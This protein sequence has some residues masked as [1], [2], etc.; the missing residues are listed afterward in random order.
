[1][2]AGRDAELDFLR[3]RAEEAE[4]GNGQVVLVRSSVG[5]GKTELLSEFARQV[6]GPNSPFLTATCTAGE[7]GLPMGVLSQLF[8][9]ASLSPALRGSL[10]QLLDRGASAVSPT[11]DTADAVESDSTQVFN[12]FL[13][14]LLELGGRRLVLLCVDDVEYAD[15]PSLRCLLYLARRLR[16]ARV[17]IVLSESRRLPGRVSALHTEVGQLPDLQRIELP[18]LSPASVA[19]LRAEC[20]PAE[21][22]ALD[23]HAATGGNPAFV[24]A[25][26]GDLGGSGAPGQ[27]YRQAVIDCLRRCEDT[28]AEVARALA[29]LGPESDRT[30]LGGLLDLRPE[31]V[32]EALALLDDVGLTVGTTFRHDMASVA[33]RDDL[34]QGRRALLHE[35]AARLLHESGK[36]AVTVARHLVDA[37]CPTGRRA[38]E[39]L[40]EASAQALS[41]DRV[42]FAVDC[43]TLALAG[44]AD[45]PRRVSVL[46]KLARAE[47]Q[48]N[49]SAMLRHVDP[50]MAGMRAGL[51]DPRDAITLVRQLLWHGRLGQ[52]REVLD[53]LRTLGAGAGSETVTELGYVERW[54]T[55]CYPSLN[56]GQCIPRSPIDQDSSRSFRA[57][58]W[59][60]S[61]AV[62]A[63]TFRLGEQQDALAEAERFLATTQL[64]NT[65][66]WS[67]EP[68]MLALLALVQGDR[69]EVAESCCERLL[70]ESTSREAPT[71]RA[72]F[73]AV[74]A[75]AALR[76]GDLGS[77]AARAR[78]AMTLVSPEAW[79]VGIGLPLGSLILAATLR[80]AYAEARG[81]V[82]QPV[83][84][85]L[86]QSRYGPHYLHARGHFYSETDCHHAALAD[87]L[88]CGELQRSWG[89]D[90]PGFVPWRTS[91]AQ[92]WLRLGNR[93]R[94][95]RLVFD[96]LARTG[97]GRTRSRALALRVLATAGQVNRRP[98]LLAEAVDIFEDRGDRLELAITLTELSRAH[99]ALGAHQR[100]RLTVRRAWHLA[101]AC[102]AEPLIRTLLSELG[103]TERIVASPSDSHGI[104]SLTGSERRVASLAVAG[105]SNREIAKKLF[106]TPSTVEQH[107]TRVYRKLRVKHR[108]DLPTYLHADLANS[109]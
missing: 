51:L 97:A 24:R 89:L 52:A 25:L 47:W 94:A 80:G 36:P 33:L 1:M 73:S 46:S 22:P 2:L 12:G 81:Y 61:A 58:P 18:A 31:R 35:R 74:A 62:L 104:K 54:L 48:L 34:P 60:R 27:E 95:K 85:T 96:Q 3:C 44:A 87:F 20:C 5:H 26:L 100:A 57:D 10:H 14:T 70:A 93:D 41:T 65:T 23:V 90:L 38:V 21:A 6:A 15:L 109:A 16:R 75:V 11:G 42:G 68:A 55:S 105:Y 4:S 37:C 103:A 43:L 84:D 7:S 102:G 88:A 8:H 86:F 53:W 79:G 91:A 82:T 29:V 99:R 13:L 39:V 28:V 56:I 59:L 72:T 19:D 63:E 76:L 101:K 108:G 30:T 77:A 69:V 71:W 66:P 67:D 106:I 17:L 50:L 49:P 32:S 83:P 92:T 98:Q 45:E 9:N 78:S 107:L 64:S 40:M